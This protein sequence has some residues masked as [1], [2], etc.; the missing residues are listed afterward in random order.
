MYYSSQGVP[1]D[2]VGAYA[3]FLLAKV[4]GNE[5]ASKWI[6]DLE[7]LLTADQ[8]EKEQARAAELHR[9]IDAK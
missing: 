4:N 9:L 2:S 7:K 8:I 6:S 1:Q 5:K 3:W